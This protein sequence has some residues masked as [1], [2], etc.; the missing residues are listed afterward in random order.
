MVKLRESYIG[1]DGVQPIESFINSI[2][3]HGRVLKSNTNYKRES[4]QDEVTVKAQMDSYSEILKFAAQDD[5]TIH[6][7]YTFLEN[8]LSCIP[9]LEN[10]DP[11]QI[12]QNIAYNQAY[13]I[14]S[15]I[16]RMCK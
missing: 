15:S 1:M 13:N 14:C 5:V 3:N 4:K 12:G 6:T 10:C 2:K 7:I 16:K 11:Y 9:E 8:K